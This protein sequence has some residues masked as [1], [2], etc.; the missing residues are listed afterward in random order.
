MKTILSL[1]FLVGSTYYAHTATC[2]SIN[3]GAWNDPLTWSCGAVPV[4]GDTIIVNAIHTVVVS[5]N[6]NL[7]GLPM[8]IIINGVLLFDS[9]GAKLRLECGSSVIIN[10]GGSVQSSGVGT[11][12]HSMSICGTDV[13][14]GPSGTLVGPVLFGV[15]PLP[16]ELI[17]FEAEEFNGI[18]TISWT[19]ASEQ[20]SDKFNVLASSDGE[21]YTIIGTIDAVGNSNEIMDYEV[22]IRNDSEDFNYFQLEQVDLNGSVNLSSVIGKSTRKNENMVVFPNPSNGNE[23][24]IDLPAKEVYVILISDLNGI[25]VYKNEF[26]ELSRIILNDLNLSSGY[27]FLN[28]AGQTTNFRTQIHVL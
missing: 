15:I 3:S 12:S 6:T 7:N 28:V 4:T 25:L 5:S 21:N 20:N 18:L 1:L 10:A 2:S 13:W 9:P 27:Y 17:S 14:S 23:L 26:S 19:T 22:E 8:V 16:V 11:P 24:Y